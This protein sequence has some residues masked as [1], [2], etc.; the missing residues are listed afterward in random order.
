[1]SNIAAFIYSIIFFFG[2]CLNRKIDNGLLYIFIVAQVLSLCLISFNIVEPE[3]IDNFGSK[4]NGIFYLFVVCFSLNT[5][6]TGGLLIYK[7]LNKLE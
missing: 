4:A 5:I 3:H 6:T 7:K 2:I 1:V